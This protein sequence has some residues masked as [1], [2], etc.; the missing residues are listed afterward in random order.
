MSGQIYL[1]GK[2]AIVTGGGRDFGRALTIWLA[3]EGIEVDLCARSLADATAAAIR[4]EGNV[5]RS[6]RCDITDPDDIARFARQF[7]DAKA[8]VDILIL[9]AAQWLEGDLADGTPT[10]E[11]ISTITS[12]LTGSVLLADALLPALRRSGE[13]TMVTMVSSCGRPGYVASNAHPAFYAAKSG[14]AGFSNILSHRLAA[15]GIRVCGVYPP[16]FETR[17]PIHP[18]E[19]PP[20]GL[21]QAEA[22][23]RGIREVLVTAGPAAD[24]LHF[25]GPT[26]KELGL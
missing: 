11:L 8:S 16:D 26:R 3:R 5:A 10:D 25:T 9:S 20:S 18:P 13:A 22:I 14:M 6:H 23:W 17:D 21:L 7:S 12:G 15:E 4:A 1:K 24:A 19:E 2:R